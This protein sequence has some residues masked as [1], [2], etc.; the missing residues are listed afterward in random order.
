MLGGDRRP[1]QQPSPADRRRDHIQT[2]LIFEELARGRALAMDHV[3]I[4][5]RMHKRESALRHHLAQALLAVREGDAVLH[6]LRTQRACGG[7]LG[8]VGVLGDEDE[9]WQPDGCGGQGDR[10][11]VVARADG[12]HACRSSAAVDQ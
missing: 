9:R 6:D 10:L 7:N 4:V 2:R 5:K 8:R 3:P 12:D 11:G 1:G